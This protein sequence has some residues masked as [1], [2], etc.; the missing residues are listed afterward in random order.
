MGKQLG[1]TANRGL[2]VVSF[3]HVKKTG[4]LVMDK[5]GTWDT[6]GKGSADNQMAAFINSIPNG[7]VVVVGAKDSAENQMS[8]VGY[9]ALKSIGGTG[10]K[11]GHR[12]GFA[13]IG[14]K[15]IGTGKGS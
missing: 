8:S 15:G 9:N 14:R 2:T 13:L 3:K 12:S 5:K 10:K 7:R 1:V 11:L 6:Y 4:K